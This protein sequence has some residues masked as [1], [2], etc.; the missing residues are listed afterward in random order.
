[1]RIKKKDFL[2]FAKTYMDFKQKKI[3]KKYFDMINFFLSVEYVIYYE[4]IVA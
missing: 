4:G 1:M 3:S 2:A